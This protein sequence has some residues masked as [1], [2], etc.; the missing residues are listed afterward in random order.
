LLVARPFG[1]AA[2]AGPMLRP[3]NP[4]AYLTTQQARS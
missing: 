2:L 3:V 1:F 4:R